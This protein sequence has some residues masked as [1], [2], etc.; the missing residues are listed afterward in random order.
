MLGDWECSEARGLGISGAIG[1]E[2][3]M[4]CMVEN[5][6]ELRVGELYL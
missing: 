2:I 5:F 3:F 1:W 4:I 6:Q